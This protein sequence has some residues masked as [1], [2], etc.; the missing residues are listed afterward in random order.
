MP[1]KTRNALIWTGLVLA[2][3]VPFGLAALSPQL[4][5]R[6]SIYIVAGFAGIAALALLLIQPLLARGVLPGVA[7][8]TGRRAHRWFG[9]S[10]VLAVVVHVGGLWITSPPDV[11]DAL[12]FTSP[13]PF[14]A[15]GV[16]AM[17]AVFAAAL[18]AGLRRRLK[19]PPRRFRLGHSALVAVV[20][21]GTVIHALLIQG[22]METISKVALCILVVGATAKVI[23]DLRAWAK[24][25]SR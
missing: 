17:W 24:S 14:S 13:T 5:W 21:A 4:A 22:T 10:L 20:V 23:W 18:L 16:I 11:V 2:L 12:T 9:L 19:I 1:L 3:A 6:Q 7:Q 15:W 8:F 25:T